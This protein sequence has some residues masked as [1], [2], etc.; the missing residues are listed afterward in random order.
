V[1]VVV[2]PVGCMMVPVMNV[3]DVV[4]V[5]HGVVAAA[6]L[7]SVFVI[8]MCYVR[9]RM[10]VVVAAMR[11]VGM[12]IMHVVGMSVMP[13]ARVAAARA[14]LVRVLGMNS[15]RIGCHRSPVVVDR[16]DAQ[17]PTSTDSAHGWAGQTK[18]CAGFGH[19]G[20]PSRHTSIRPATWTNTVETPLVGRRVALV[21]I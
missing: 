12:A 11:R 9:E 8:S 13:D 7:V 6:G 4:A 18:S 3:V 2:V 21:L 14:M 19:A 10:L 17:V 16:V 20:L 1:L 15:V 5:L